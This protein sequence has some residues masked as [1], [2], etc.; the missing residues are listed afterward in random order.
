MT[1]ATSKAAPQAAWTFDES[2]RDSLI[3]N[4]ADARRQ[5]GDTLFIDVRAGA[6]TDLAE[7]EKAH[8]PGAVYANVRGAF[9]GP[10]SAAQ[11]SLPLPDIA[12]LQQKVNEWGVGEDTEII[13]YGP[14][15]A[16]VARA[17]WVLKWAGLSHARLLDGGLEA[18]KIAGGSVQ[19]GTP[20]QRAAASRAVTL[21][22]GHLPSIEVDDVA[23]AAERGILLDARDPASY[24]AGPA[25]EGQPP[26][27][28]IPGAL[29]LPAA[30]A[31]DQDGK[32]RSP[33]ELADLFAAAGVTPDS[34]SVTAYCGGGVL[35]TYDV[36]ALHSLGIR[37]SLYV[38]SWSQ[39]SADPLRPRAHGNSPH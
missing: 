22:A 39:W 25:V 20:A 26:V 16:F 11:G 3:V 13:V 10:A 15:P 12:A 8:I 24:A 36:L 9:A 5:T 32:L 1:T 38:G 7:F 35:A 17:W 21:T 37:T 2:I 29:N 18:W 14:Q 6:E 31:W 4:A 33:R 34:T 30:Q 28:H 27:G 23:D 19:E